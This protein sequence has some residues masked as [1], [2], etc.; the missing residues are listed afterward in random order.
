[1]AQERDQAVEL[2]QGNEAC[3]LGALAAGVSF[4]AGYPIT[5]SSE[6]AETMSRRLPLGGGTFIQME[7]EIASIAAIVG[8]SLAGAK[9]M[10]ATSGPGFSLMQ[11]NIGFACMAE[12]PCVIVN[13]QRAGPSTGLPTQPAQMDVM[14]TRWGTHGDHAIIAVSPAS[15]LESYEMT[16]RAVDLAERFRTPVVVLMDEVIGHMRERIRT[17]DPG[18]YEVPKRRVP[19]PGTTDYRPYVSDAS[20]VALLAPFGGELRFHVTGLTHD[21]HGFPTMAQSEVAKQITGIVEKIEA[22]ADDLA[23]NEEFMTEDCDVLVFAYGSTARVAKS[24]VRALRAS[25][26]KAGL[27]RVKTLWPFSV[28]RIRELAGRVRLIV[29]PEMNQGQMVL[30]VQRVVCGAA[31]VKHLGRVDGELFEPHQI[32]E[33]VQRETER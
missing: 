30:E 9:S 10:T 14:Q 2:L 5:P 33:Y 3:A 13:V 6:I 12:V 28:S 17:P 20:G 23:D 1:M 22:H 8:A 31:P 27:L 32:T 16:M 7:D 11:E 15:V 4:F 25:G 24:S 19:P 26:V 18:S 21:E 29:V